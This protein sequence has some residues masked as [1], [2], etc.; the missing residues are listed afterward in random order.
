MNPQKFLFNDLA[1]LDT[2]VMKELNEKSL[3]LCSK[4]ELLKLYKEVVNASDAYAPKKFVK[5]FI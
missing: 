4:E 2:D 5:D 3:E 1:T